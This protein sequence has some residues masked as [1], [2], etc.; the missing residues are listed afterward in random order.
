ML[1][2]IQQ[3]PNLAHWRPDKNPRKHRAAPNAGVVLFYP[4]IFHR[5][6]AVEGKVLMRRLSR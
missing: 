6:G 4:G 3:H 2:S 5:A 1:A